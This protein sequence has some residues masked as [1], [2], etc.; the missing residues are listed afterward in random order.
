MLDKHPASVRELSHKARG[1][2]PKPRQENRT[3]VHSIEA[4]GMTG[5]FAY[6]YQY[7]TGA[8]HFFGYTDTLE[9][10]QAILREAG[11]I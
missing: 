5:G 9:E 4:T 6:R 7:Q 3:M 10:A 8:N 2:S 1:T 11:V